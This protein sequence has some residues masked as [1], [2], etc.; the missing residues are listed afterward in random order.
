MNVLG[1]IE[2]LLYLSRRIKEDHILKTQDKED[3]L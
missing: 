1:D 2:D 3:Q